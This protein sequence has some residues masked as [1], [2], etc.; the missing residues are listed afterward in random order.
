MVE[1]NTN[2]FNNQARWFA[3]LSNGEN[4]VE[5]I[6][7][8]AEIKGELSPWQKLLAYIK[9]NNLTITGMQIRIEGRIYTLP[10]TNPKFGG[11]IPLSYKF[12]RKVAADMMSD[13][14]GNIQLAE[15]H[16]F[17]TAVYKDF[18]CTLW[19]DEMNRKNC[20]VS[21]IKTQ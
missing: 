18:E 9:E 11:E 13:N 19:V 10:S 16:I 2:N 21:I 12:G 7:K 8:F 4:A 5:G 3:S 17:I 6:D 15:M 1:I 20:W 14:M